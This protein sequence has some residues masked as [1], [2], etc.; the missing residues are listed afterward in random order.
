MLTFLIIGSAWIGIFM[1]IY[2]IIK[3]CIGRKMELLTTSIM[4]RI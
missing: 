4:S 1:I 2:L 3:I